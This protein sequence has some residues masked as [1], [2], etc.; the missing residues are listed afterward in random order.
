MH[1]AGYRWLRKIRSVLP[2]DL[3]PEANANSARMLGWAR[4]KL[5]PDSIVWTQVES[6]IAKDLWLRLKLPEETFL[7]RGNHEPYV[8]AL[9]ASALRPGGVVYDVGS[10]L[11]F[12]AL[13]MARAIG[14]AGQ[15]VAFEPDPENAGRLRANVARNHMEERIRVVEAA[16]WR[17]SLDQVPY[18]RGDQA[19]SQGGV[20][21]DGIQPVLA[22]G[23]QIAVRSISLDEF[24]AANNPVPQLLKIDVE[25]GELAVIAGAEGLIAKGRPVLIC[26]VHHV[27]AVRWLEQWFPRHGYRLEW[28]IPPEEFP[29]HLV[30]KPA[31]RS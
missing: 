9:L 28:M 27:A 3:R 22:T 10:Y 19:R 31:P 30:A 11:G 18:R 21:A 26:E 16:V 7:W 15:V 12:F 4:K 5:V 29:R 24:I 13:A 1:P 25:G 14:P 20:V 17:R 8:Q 2:E 6:G 23:E